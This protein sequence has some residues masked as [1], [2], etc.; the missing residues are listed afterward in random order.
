MVDIQDIT[1]DSDEG[2]DLDA[3]RLHTGAA[4]GPSVA[5]GGGEEEN[6]PPSGAAS[7]P[8]PGTLAGFDE[9]LPP[10][11]DPSPVKGGGRRAMESSGAP[12]APCPEPALRHLRPPSLTAL[13]SRLCLWCAD[14][15]LDQRRV[16]QALAERRR[17]HLG[18]RPMSEGKTAE[19][20]EP[21]RSG[22]TQPPCHSR[23]Q[24]KGS[25]LDCGGHC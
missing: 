19:G 20:K 15:L 18:S 4:A 22:A 11:V 16:D 12:A 2:D 3:Y 5:A 13:P 17:R 24:K 6:S 25:G 14:A 10:H 1:D 21:E 8:P 9:G 23:S 7:P